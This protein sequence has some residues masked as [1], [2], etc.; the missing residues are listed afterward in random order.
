MW[1]TVVAGLAIFLM[2]FQ[3]PVAN[4][5]PP[6]APTVSADAGEYNAVGESFPLHIT[7][8]ADGAESWEFAILEGC[9]PAPEDWHTID[10]WSG[11]EVAPGEFLAGEW[12]P[13][14]TLCVG[15][16]AV[17]VDG[18][19]DA[20]FTGAF[21]LPSAPPPAAP[22]SLLTEDQEAALFA[23]RD[24]AVVIA[25]GVAFALFFLGYQAVRSFAR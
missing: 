24:T 7:V 6:G 13:G 22:E 23:L 25:A 5:A 15:A 12:N 8:S 17:N 18:V 19:S 10:Y 1:V 2:T 20:V 11:S 21:D 9:T 14:L 3:A 4:A 16:R